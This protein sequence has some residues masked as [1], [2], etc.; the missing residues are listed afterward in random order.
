MDI[1]R[2][3]LAPFLSIAVGLAG[4]GDDGD[5][6]KTDAGKD[7]GGED[8]GGEDAGGKPAGMVLDLPGKDSMECMD[9]FG[10]GFPTYEDAEC[11]STAGSEAGKENSCAGF[12]CNWTE[13][14]LLCNLPEDTVCNTDV[15]LQYACDRTLQDTIATCA[16]GA[17]EDIVASIIEPDQYEEATAECT[18][19]TLPKQVSPACL[20]CYIESASCALD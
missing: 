10:A 1:G 9:A 4:C 12:L 6:G 15:D 2:I 13:T 11:M 16:R 17:A 18:R 3:A 5:G 7:A 20:D 8:A 19:E 14:Q